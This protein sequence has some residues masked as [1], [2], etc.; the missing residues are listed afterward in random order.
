MQVKRSDFPDDFLWGASTA[1][2]QVEG[3]LV[4][5]WSVWELAHAS[6][7]AKT[8]E[9]RLGWMASWPEVK[10][11]AETPE[12]Y[13]SGKAVDHYNQYPQDFKIIK[14]MGLNSFRFGIEWARLEPLEGQWD[15]AAVK[16]YKEY[17][18]ALK[19]QGIEPVLNIWHWTVPVWFAQKGGF[20]K[21]S[22]L[23]YFDRFVQL[24]ADEFCEVLRYII[25]LNE[26]N[27]Y[28]YFGYINGDWPP[29]H[30]NDVRQFITTNL[31][32]V[33][34]HKRAY[35]IL[36]RAHPKLQIGLAPNLSNNLPKNPASFIDR[37]AGKVADHFWNYLFLDRVRNQCDF[38][39]FN[40]YFTNE[41]TI[42]GVD[43]PKSPTNDM[44]WY[45]HPEGVRRLLGQMYGRYGKPIIITENGIADASDSQRQAW[46]ETT[47]EAM[48]G[49]RQDGVQLIGYLHWSL[50]DNFEWAEGWWPKFGLIAV[51]REDGFRRSPRN[52]A[53]WWS[54]WLKA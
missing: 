2:H 51:D 8:A 14:A 3:G 25:T 11:Q 26:V 32:L 19:A 37:L 34:A 18:A 13:V 42:K 52:S 41:M 12:N 1:S 27:N 5:Q 21:K 30:R 40:Y 53:K 23:K 22:N 9:R 28:T 17:I 43:N 48:H 54:R 16:H 10:A 35:R 31:A 20:A 46:L 49:A 7:R 47:I 45:V 6:E 39:G 29:G 4:N 44:G 24:I 15:T 36:K 50:L 33:Q 38:T